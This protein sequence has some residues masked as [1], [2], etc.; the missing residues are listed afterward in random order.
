MFFSNSPF[1]SST[2]LTLPPC[3]SFCLRNAATS[4]L[5]APNSPSLCCR[6]V[7]WCSVWCGVVWCSVVWCGVV[8]CGV[9]W[10]GVVWCGVVWCGV[11]W[12]GVV[13][14]GVVCCACYGSGSC[15]CG[16]WSRDGSGLVGVKLVTI[17][18][19][20]ITKNTTATPPTTT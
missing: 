4:P 9:V 20:A 1:A 18:T 19:P 7:V 6:G 16:G 17:T 11:V 8:W 15:R 3:C 14:C 10:C 5:N 2:T 12:C 13:W